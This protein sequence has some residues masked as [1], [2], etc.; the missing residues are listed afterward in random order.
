MLE[1]CKLQFPTPKP[2]KIPNEEKEFMKYRRISLK[3]LQVESH[4]N[5]HYVEFTLIRPGFKDLVPTVHCIVED[6][7]TIYLFILNN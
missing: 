2:Y 3:D 7:G 6:E 5:Y 1:E 4:H